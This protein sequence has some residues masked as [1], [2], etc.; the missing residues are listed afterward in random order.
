MSG[1]KGVDRACRTC[2][3]TDA[4]ACPG[5]CSWVEADL[6]S[7]CVPVLAY[8]RIHTRQSLDR[9]I[10]Q[11]PKHTAMLVGRRPDPGLIPEEYVQTIDRTIAL[12]RDWLALRPG[13]RPAF[14]LG[15]RHIMVVSPLEVLADA[16][17]VNADAREFCDVAIAAEAATEGGGRGLTVFM[18]G[19]CLEMLRLPV[20][21]VSIEQL[22]IAIAPPG[23]GGSS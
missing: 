16:L 20:E 9:R 6:C 15:P 23:P 12:L 13:F 3:C 14:R 10:G 5:G 22:G 19:V 11:K 7:A 4:R 8:P 18:F 1:E 2:G 21:R 17:S